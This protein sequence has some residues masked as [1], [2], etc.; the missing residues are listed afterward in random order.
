MRRAYCLVREAPVYR[1]H[2]FRAGLAAAG[3]HVSTDVPGV[4]NPGDVLVTWNRYMDRHELAKRF[5]AAGGI[6]LV[7]ENG[8]IL[9]GGGSPHEQSPRESFALARSYHNDETV[10]PPGDASRWDALHVELKPWREDGRHILVCPNRS[11]GT[12]GRFMPIGWAENVAARLRAITKREIRVR[13]HPQNSPPVKPLADD[14]AGAWATVIWTSSAGVHSLVAGVPV[15]CEAPF[16][17]CKG[18]TLPLNAYVGTALDHEK[19]FGTDFQTVARA[20][21][22]ERLAWAQW[23]LQEVADGS[24]FRYLLSD[25]GRKMSGPMQRCSAAPALTTP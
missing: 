19:T 1:A 6:V 3:F 15:I 13:P 4:I 21:V 18:A 25:D 14:L 22:M 16:W 12:P 17:I 7:A 20:E 8:Y 23:N 5:E 2:A 9:P 24:A 10:I 11:F